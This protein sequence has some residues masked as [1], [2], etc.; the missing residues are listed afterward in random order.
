MTESYLQG[1]THTI[2]LAVAPVFLLTALGTTLSVLTARL[3]RIVDRARR[4]EARLG[5]EEVNA[6]AASVEELRMLEGRVRLIHVA[7]T[8]GTCAAL[9]VCLLIAVS[10]VGYLLGARV[11]TI[12]AVLFIAAMTAYV[13]ALI[14]FLREVFAAIDTMRFNLPAELRGGGGAPAPR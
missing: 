5:D 13:G 12:M 8:L 14:C 6:R 2:Q 4:V 3:A 7:L 10:F 11:G 9:L 1:I